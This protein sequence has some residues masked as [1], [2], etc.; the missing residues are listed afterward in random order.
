MKAVLLSIKPEFAHKIFEGS[1]KFEFRKQVFKDTSVKKVI[2]Y[3]SSPEQKVIGEFE[4]ETILSDTPNNIWIQTKLY[5]GISQEFY[6][7]YFK[8]RD[9]AYA[10]KVASTKKYR[11]EKSLADYNVQSAP[12][13]FAYVE[14]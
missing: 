3:S 2:V 13:S 4:I 14:V 9:N 10:I 12:Q 8:G 6:D 1:K 11:K 7:E 5:S